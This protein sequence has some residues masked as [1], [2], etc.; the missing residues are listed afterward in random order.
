MSLLDGVQGNAAHTTPF[1]TDMYSFHVRT[2]RYPAL[3][4]SDPVLEQ[5]R[6]GDGSSFLFIFEIKHIQELDHQES[7][8]RVEV[9]AGPACWLYAVCPGD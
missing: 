2:G 9:E 6:L 5:R 7:V 3:C 8:V 1:T 4:L